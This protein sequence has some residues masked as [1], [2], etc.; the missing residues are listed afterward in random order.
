MKHKKGCKTKED[1]NE[2]ESFLMIPENLMMET[3]N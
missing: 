1:I 3:V 2:N